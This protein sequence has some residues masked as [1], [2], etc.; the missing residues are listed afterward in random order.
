RESEISHKSKVSDGSE[1]S[2]GSRVAGESKVLN[3][4][5]VRGSEVSNWSEVLHRSIVQGSKVL[6]G[7]IVSDGSKVYRS[8]ISNGSIVSD[9]YLFGSRVDGLEIREG[10]ILGKVKRTKEAETSIK[11]IV[12]PET[13]KLLARDDSCIQRKSFNGQ[14]VTTISSC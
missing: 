4:S 1:V 12:G 3:K 14:N 8:E 10:K 2:D 7:S 13:A 9:T 11:P 5:I 6:N